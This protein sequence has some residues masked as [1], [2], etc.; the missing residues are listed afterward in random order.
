MGK[1][2]VMGDDF[3]TEEDKKFLDVYMANGFNASAALISIGKSPSYSRSHGYERLMKPA[4]KKF[5]EDTQKKSKLKLDNKFEVMIDK[6]MQL[7]YFY[8]PDSGDLNA[9]HAA[10]AIAAIKEINL[11][12]G[13]YPKDNTLNV[14][15]NVDADIQQLKELVDKYRKEY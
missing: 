14:N 11:M 5:I 8:V 2:T 4:V 1:R 15:L 3:L 9:Q 7:I 13:N 6:L 12:L 10:K